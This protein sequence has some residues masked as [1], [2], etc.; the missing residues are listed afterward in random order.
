[1][2]ITRGC[3]LERSELRGAI[4]YCLKFRQELTQFTRDLRLP[5]SNNGAEREIRH[6]L[7]GRE[8]FNGSKT[9]IGAD[10]A[11]SIYT[12]IESCKRV[13]LQPGQN[14]KNL[15]EARHFRDEIQ[16]PFERSMVILTLKMKVQFTQEDVWQI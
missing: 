10:T 11:A 4:S 8:Y 7:T 3:Y 12:V 6:I 13:D 16:T 1:M 9:I 14:L 15:V 5:L 2:S